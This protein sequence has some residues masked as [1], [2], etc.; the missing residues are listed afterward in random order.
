MRATVKHSSPYR[1][2][3]VPYIEFIHHYF[4]QERIGMLFERVKN[5]VTALQAARA[6]GLSVNRNGKALCPFHPDSNPSMKVDRRYYCFGCGAIS[7][8]SVEEIK[9][10]LS[11]QKETYK[12]PYTKFTKDRPRQCVFVGTSNK[13][14]FLPLDRTGNR[15]FFPIQ[16]SMEAAEVHVLEN[17]AESRRYI[18]QMWAEIM[19]LYCSGNWSLKLSPELSHR[20]DMHRL[21]F[22]AE[23]TTTGILQAWLDKFSVD[24]VCYPAALQ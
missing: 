6:Y 17:E 1:I 9:A 4:L 3:S 24:Y 10:F 23:D 22:M 2:P 15:R 19:V 14:R 16:V 8:R 13:Q 18:D 12:T 7:A 21:E 5:S 11:R 20:M